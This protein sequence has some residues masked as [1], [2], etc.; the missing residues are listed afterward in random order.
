MIVPVDFL[1][2]T[3]FISVALQYLLIA[4]PFTLSSVPILT[5]NYMVALYITSSFLPQQT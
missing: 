2:R 1:G 3:L 4:L 5:T